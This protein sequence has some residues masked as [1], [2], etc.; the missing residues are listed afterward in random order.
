M[1]MALRNALSLNA[2]RA[3]VQKNGAKRRFANKEN[4]DIPHAVAKRWAECIRPARPGDGTPLS[5]RGDRVSAA[6]QR[7]VGDIASIERIG[8]SDPLD[9]GIRLCARVGDVV[10]EGA[11]REDAATGAD[12]RTL[13]IRR[14]ACVDP[15]R[16][17]AEARVA[18]FN[19]IAGSHLAGIPCCRE[20]DAQRW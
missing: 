5:W 3:C 11:Y 9:G 13:R 17:A 15:L 20:H 12:G 6:C 14:G 10:A 8:Q 4:W 16:A 1:T 18:A 7:A 2:P 19:D